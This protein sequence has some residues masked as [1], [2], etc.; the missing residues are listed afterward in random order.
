MVGDKVLWEPE[1][2]QL[3][4]PLIK[5]PL[6]SPVESRL[7]A[8]LANTWLQEPRKIAH[9]KPNLRE[10]YTKQLED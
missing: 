7:S 2:V 1:C 5:S 9:V 10:P 6:G 8:I 4:P 3:P